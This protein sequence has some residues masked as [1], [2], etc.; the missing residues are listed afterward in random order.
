MAVNIMIILAGKFI[1]KQ[2]QIDEVESKLQGNLQNSK[3]SYLSISN[4]I[5][6]K[7]R[8]RIWIYFSAFKNNIGLF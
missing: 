8:T 5:Q 3:I 4:D 6:S 2:Q 1:T 7:V